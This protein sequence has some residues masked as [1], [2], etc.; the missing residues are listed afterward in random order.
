MPIKVQ[1]RTHPTPPPS[2]RYPW[3]INETWK[4]NFFTSTISRL[5]SFYTSLS[6]RKENFLTAIPFVGVAL[7]F[8]LNLSCWTLNFHFTAITSKTLKVEISRN[9]SGKMKC[10]TSRK[11]LDIEDENLGQLFRRYF[12]CHVLV[13]RAEKFLIKWVG[14]CEFRHVRLG[15]PRLL[16]SETSSEQ[17]LNI[18]RALAVSPSS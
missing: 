2:V 9:L 5:H 1:H 13:S 4:T 15:E 3:D 18:F 12:P 7:M 6:E 17:N 14:G 11:Y 8:A 10:V 16:L